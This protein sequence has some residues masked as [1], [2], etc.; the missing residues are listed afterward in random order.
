MVL[1]AKQRTAVIYRLALAAFEHSHQAISSRCYDDCWREFVRE[2]RLQ[3]WE[4]WA[5]WALT[6]KWNMGWMMVLLRFYEEDPIYHSTI[7]IWWLSFIC[8]FWKFPL[9]FLSRL[10]SFSKKNMIVKMWGDR[11]HC[12]S[13]LLTIKSAIRQIALVEF[14][15]WSIHKWKSRRAVGMVQI[16]TIIWISRCKPSLL[17]SMPSIKTIVPLGDWFELWWHRNH[18]CRQPI[19]S[20]IRKTEKRGYAMCVQYEFMIGTKTL[21][22]VCQWRPFMKYGILS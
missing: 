19:L 16:W 11:Y 2:P 18:W 3:V 10:E 13:D 14:K 4:R 5:V 7:S 22:L 17:S 6:S 1:N 12:W 8:F 21:Q 15:I 9:A 20:F